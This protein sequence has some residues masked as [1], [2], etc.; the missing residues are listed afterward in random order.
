MPA[1]AL[2]AGLLN[3]HTET[4]ASTT[5]RSPTKIDAGA[6]SATIL[7]APLPPRNPRTSQQG[8]RRRSKQW[9]KL[10]P[11]TL[12]AALG[13]GVP[14]RAFRTLARLAIHT[15]GNPDGVEFP[16]AKIATAQAL[17]VRTVQ[18]D[19][20][21]LEG[22]IAE[23]SVARDLDEHAARPPMNRPNRYTLP[24]M[25][26]TEPGTVIF[27]ALL[28]H[29]A[30]IAATPTAA[31]ILLYLL[32]FLG[33]GGD[34]V[35]VGELAYTVKLAPPTVRDALRYWR[36]TGFLEVEERHD[37]RG[38]QMPNLYKMRLPRD[39][40]DE[41]SADAVARRR[42]QTLAHVT[43]WIGLIVA[44]KAQDNP[45]LWRSID[46][47]AAASTAAVVVDLVAD[48]RRLRELGIYQGPARAS[49]VHRALAVV[50]ERRELFAGM[51]AE[52]VERGD[53]SIWVPD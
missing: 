35:R 29:P 52:R 3:T 19:V 25:N 15:N 44:D 24:Q 32:E 26:N 37:R 21:A 5:I 42:R 9:G 41:R 47:D 28:E 30:Y 33:P 12:R 10:P 14:V 40:P 43:H 22:G 27:R 2:F 6:P 46:E 13:A 23:L 20:K 51:Q 48:L 31:G 16:N 38:G 11:G 8:P 1:F 49:D 50:L 17:S 45:D 4:P 39:V 18:R 34:P 36:S 53:A 7:N